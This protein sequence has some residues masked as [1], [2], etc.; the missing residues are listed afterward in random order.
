[1]ADKVA[2]S[3]LEGQRKPDKVAAALTAYEP[4]L[5]ERIGNATYDVARYLGLPYANRMRGDIE[6]AVD[7]IP[8]VGDVVG[9]NEAVRD[10]QAGNYLGALGGMGLAA[11]GMVP[12]V[13]DAVAK[14]LK[15]LPSSASLNIPTAPTVEQLAQYATLQPVPLDM[16]R[17]SQPRMDWNKFNSGQ[18]GEPMFP[19]YVDAPVAARRRDGEYIVYDGHHRSVK[20]MNEGS[21]EIPM[22]VIDASVYDPSNAGIAPHQAPMPN[23]GMT[24]EELLRELGL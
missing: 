14:G 7:F 21:P 15:A 10:Y 1:V 8:G 20:A 5:R 18:Y 3:L 6:T 24:D 2:A 4:S 17:G 22:Y 12:A 13:G 11:V 19:G 16:A 9:A 23:I